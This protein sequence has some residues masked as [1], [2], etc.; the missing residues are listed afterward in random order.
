M[1]END[2]SSEI[3]RWTEKLEAN[4]QNMGKQRLLRYS[5]IFDKDDDAKPGK[6]K[7]VKHF[8]NTGDARPILQSPRRVPLAKREA[9]SQT[10][11]EMSE[12]SVSESMELTCSTCEEEER[13]QHEILCRL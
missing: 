12:S 6:T 13:W 1:D 10:I 11:R 4:H 5:S 2:I 3:N 8:Y 7:V 9:I